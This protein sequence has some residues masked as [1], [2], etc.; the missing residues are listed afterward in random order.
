MIIE[1]NG[2]VLSWGWNARGTLG[3]GTKYVGSTRHAFSR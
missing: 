3:Q 2:E 1:H